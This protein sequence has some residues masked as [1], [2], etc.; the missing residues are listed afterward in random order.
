MERSRW[1]LLEHF[2]FRV[3]NVE[4]KIPKIAMLL[5]GSQFA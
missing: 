5:S 2:M 4:L 3:S 1:G